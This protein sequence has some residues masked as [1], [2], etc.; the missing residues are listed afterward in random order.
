MSTTYAQQALRMPR[1]RQ[2]TLM[3]AAFL[4]GALLA[5]TATLALLASTSMP[6]AEKTPPTR[7]YER[8]AGRGEM[9]YPGLEAPTSL[10]L[11]PG[12]HRLLTLRGG[13]AEY[14]GLEA[15]RAPLGQAHGGLQRYAG[16]R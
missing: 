10:S 8:P 3:L 12:P 4:A 2:S 13:L 16:T 1:A 7:T 15:P 5:T 11:G 9:E 6:A 14:P